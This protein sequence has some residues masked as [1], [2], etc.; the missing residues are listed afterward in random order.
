MMGCDWVLFDGDGY[1]I[2]SIN[3]AISRYQQVLFL[4]Y[5]SF[6]PLCSS[7]PIRKDDEVTVTRGRF[8]GSSGKVIQVKTAKCKMI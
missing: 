6:A 4:E 3:E 7:V 2:V 1:R 8:K 5:L